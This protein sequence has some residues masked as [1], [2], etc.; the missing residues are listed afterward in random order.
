ME[1]S[2]AKIESSLHRQGLRVGTENEGFRQGSNRGVQEIKG[3]RFGKHAQVFLGFR[4]LSE[5]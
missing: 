2:W 5:R 4:L 3:F 1:F